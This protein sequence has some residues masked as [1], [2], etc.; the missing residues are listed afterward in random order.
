MSTMLFLPVSTGSFC[1]GR[2][3]R[4]RPMPDYTTVTFEPDPFV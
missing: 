1:T 4:E 3:E 2:P